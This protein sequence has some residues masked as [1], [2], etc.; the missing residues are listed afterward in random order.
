LSIFKKSSPKINVMQCGLPL[1]K[2]NFQQL[3]S[4]CAGKAT[5]NQ[6]ACAQIVTKNYNWQADFQK[7]IIAFG[8]SIFPVQFIGSESNISHT[9]LWSWANSNIS[10]GVKK[11]ALV[12]KKFGEEQGITEFITP[13]FEV[14]GLT[15]I[16]PIL[17]VAAMLNEDNVCYYRG[18][19]SGGA[20]GMIFKNIPDEVFQL[21]S[22]P[23]F[24]DITMRMIRQ[25]ELVHQI[26]V[27][28]FLIQNKCKYE[29]TDNLLNA[30]FPDK[31]KLAIQFDDLGRIASIKSI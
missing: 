5:A 1:Q 30:F 9:W 11:D 26:F 17:M 14:G 16:H 10:D 25:Y 15:S 2:G 24:V 12:L 23:R 19:Y 21:V 7:G 18:P 13:E 6:E 20:A 28:S 4:A 27:E 3:L 29:W 31:T 22:A 8:T